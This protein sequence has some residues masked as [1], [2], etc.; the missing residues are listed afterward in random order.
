M[1]WPA[2]LLPLCVMTQIAAAQPPAAR[3]EAPSLAHSPVSGAAGPFAKVT[4]MLRRTGSQPHAPFTGEMRLPS[5]RSF[6]LAGPDLPGDFFRID[7]TAVVFTPIDRSRTNG[8]VI[9]YDSSQIG[10]QHGTDHLALV[11]RVTRDAAVNV[12]DAE[13]Q[14][15]GVRNAAQARRAL[16]KL[17]SGSLM[18]RSVPLQCLKLLQGAAFCAD[19]QALLP[20][21]LVA[22][23]PCRACRFPGAALARN[24][25]ARL[26]LPR[27]DTPRRRTGQGCR[28][29]F[30]PTQPGAG[31]LARQV[32]QDGRFCP[33]MGEPVP[34]PRSMSYL[35]AD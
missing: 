33:D 19:P 3:Q 6:A 10:P 11:Y 31:P 18:A 17:R 7:V 22:R 5:G 24:D 23:P 20:S 34:Q 29:L 12:P 8:V 26:R 32:R 25:R 13:E 2:L 4:V 16:S 15:N 21:L 1:N 28:C 35:V 30:P 14:L 27:Q 9:L